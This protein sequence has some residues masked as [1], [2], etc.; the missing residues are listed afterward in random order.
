MLKLPGKDVYKVKNGPEE[1]EVSKYC[2]RVCLR[3][4]TELLS[5]K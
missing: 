4:F 1:I 5:R 2:S 3:A